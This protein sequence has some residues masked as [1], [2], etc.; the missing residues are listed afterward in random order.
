[1]ALQLLAANNASTLLVSGISAAST[2]LQ[3]STGTGDLFPSPVPG[4]SYF[5]VTLTSLAAGKTKEIVHVTARSGDTLTITRGQEGTAAASWDSGASVANL[6]TAGTF[7]DLAQQMDID[8]V[9]TDLASTAAGKGTELVFNK[10]PLAGAVAR[11][12]HDK[13]TDFRTLEDFGAIGDGA[14]HPL[15]ERFSTLTAAQ[16]VYSFVTSL[17]QSIDWAAAMAASAAGGFSMLGKKYSLSQTLNIAGK[18]SIQGVGD[19][20][21]DFLFT[22]T[23]NGIVITLTNDKDSKFWLKGFGILRTG[24]PSTDLTKETGLKIDGRA[25]ILIPGSSTTLAQIGYR[26]EFRGAIENIRIAGNDVESSG[27]FRG[28]HTISVMNFRIVGFAYCGYV[29]SSGVFVGEA[30]TVAGDGYVVDFSIS[31]FWIFYCNIAFNFPDYVEG[32]HVHDFE[33]MNVNTGMLGGIVQSETVVPTITGQISSP[34]VLSPWVHDGHMNCLK[35]TILM[36][37]NCNLAK[38]HNLHLFCNPT[39]TDTQGRSAISLSYGTGCQI[40]D[41][42]V[43]QDR[44]ANT[45]YLDSNSAIF[46]GSMTGCQVGNI[47]HGAVANRGSGIIITDGT[48]DN[49]FGPIKTNA[50]YGV[51][52]IGTTQRNSFGPVAPGFGTAR[53]NIATRDLNSFN[54]DVVSRTDTIT[55]TGPTGG[56]A[57]ESY[58]DITP[59]STLSEVPAEV[60]VGLAYSDAPSAQAYYDFD[61]STVSR[62][63]IRVRATSIPAGAKV[64]RTFVQYPLT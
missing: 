21:S 19:G 64:F 33:L 17:T 45:A 59:I 12:Q 11:S 3:V 24:I 1:M 23:G 44:S 25:Q 20:L 32:V 5:K 2:T 56:G 8:Q 63:R 49:K 10:S 13:N 46:L 30:I 29:Q 60:Y 40:N 51:S 50:K 34:G 37:S 54:Y 62:I 6:F 43:L 61:G 14:N 7:N 22:G 41:I 57:A 28:I 55:L 38:F 39:S 48:N 9:Y 53:F 31:R 27:W 35:E 15:S 47:I 52:G 4:T 36:P 16:M 26:T 42:Y 18:I 58:F